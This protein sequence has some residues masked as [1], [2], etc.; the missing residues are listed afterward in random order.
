MDCKIHM[1]RKND[2][3]RPWRHLRDRKS[4]KTRLSIMDNPPLHPHDTA[5]TEE[6]IH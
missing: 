4:L 3:I 6:L 1:V 5:D 2:Q